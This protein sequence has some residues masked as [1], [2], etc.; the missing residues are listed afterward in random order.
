MCLG[1]FSRA[2]QL[3]DDSNSADVWYNL[4]QVCDKCGH[5]LNTV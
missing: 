3:S 2:L 1:C 5:W 4:G